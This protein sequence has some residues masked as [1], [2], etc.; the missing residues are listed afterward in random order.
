M[1]AL[2]GGYCSRIL[3]S[4]G[5][6]RDASNSCADTVGWVVLSGRYRKTWA[7]LSML[8]ACATIVMVIE[9]QFHGLPSAHEHAAPGGHHHSHSAPGY[10]AVGFSGLIAVLPPGTPLVMFASV[11]FSFASLLL[12]S[13]TLR[14]PLFIPP[15]TA[16][17]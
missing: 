5:W 16:T 4:S 14:F 10:A 8:L 13:T 17:C 9:C 15:R 3:R 2:T 7:I 12:R 11:L 6:T 1:F